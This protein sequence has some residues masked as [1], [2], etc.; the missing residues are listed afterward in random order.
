MAPRLTLDLACHENAH[1]QEDD[2]SCQ[3]DLSYVGDG[4]ECEY[5]PAMLYLS[6]SDLRNELKRN[7]EGIL[8]FFLKGLI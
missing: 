3:C 5:S 7:F 6:T 4:Y 2:Y 8:N 1:C